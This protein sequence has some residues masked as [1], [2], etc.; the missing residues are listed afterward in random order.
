M[1][2]IMKEDKIKTGI[3]STFKVLA[4]TNIILCGIIN[5][6]KGINYFQ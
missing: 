3:V 4:S 6:T 1:E 5:K 2:Q